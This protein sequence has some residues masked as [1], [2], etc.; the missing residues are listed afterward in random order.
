MFSLLHS[1]RGFGDLD[2]VGV[3]TDIMRVLHSIK[4]PKLSVSNNLGGL[5]EKMILVLLPLIIYS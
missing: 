2:H 4:L 3:K 5:G 1:V